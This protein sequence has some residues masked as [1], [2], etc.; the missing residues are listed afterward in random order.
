M[1]SRKDSRAKVQL[2]KDPAESVGVFWTE[3]RRA[4]EDVTSRLDNLALTDTSS[5]KISCSST[6]ISCCSS[7]NSTVEES[8]TYL[9]GKVQA[10]D[11]Q[12]ADA[13][14]FL[15]PYD[16]RRAQEEAS[17]LRSK[18]EKVR[19]AFT[20]RKRFS[21]ASRRRTTA[22]ATATAAEEERAVNGGSDELRGESTNSSTKQTWRP[23]PSVAPTSSKASPNTTATTSNES[24][25]L[26]AMEGF[27]SHSDAT[28][29]LNTLLSTTTSRS[30]SNSSSSIIISHPKDLLLRD[31][32]R[33]TIHLLAPL[34]FLRLENLIDCKLLCGPVVGPVYLEQ[35]Q[36]CTLYLASRQLRI[37]CTYDT[38][39]YV[40]VTSG[41]VIEDCDGLKF[42]PWAL[43][44]PG[45]RKSVV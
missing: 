37:H 28:L 41:P 22:A 39:L 38:T 35:C 6:K 42:A 40:H 43:T 8:L 9:S 36:G 34:H 33:C 15:P 11:K 32:T 30:S 16:V 44:Y 21:F 12:I 24:S 10:L 1:Q 45:D 27:S 14:L 29:N 3:L 13:A 31:L 25:G 20:P 23:T 7:I 2:G 5:T 4:H 19:A 26:T 18:L 17:A